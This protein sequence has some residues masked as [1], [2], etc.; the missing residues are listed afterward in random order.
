MEVDC[1]T[2]SCDGVGDAITYLLAYQQRERSYTIAIPIKP[3]LG[4]SWSNLDTN[5]GAAFQITE[6][7]LAAGY[8]VRVLAAGLTVVGSD[9]GFWQASLGLPRESYYRHENDF[10]V[11]VDQSE[12]ASV[13]LGR[14]AS[15]SAQ[16]PTPIDRVS[17]I[18]NA[19]PFG[20]WRI[21]FLKRPSGPSIADASDALLHLEISARAN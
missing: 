5:E 2:S 3:L 14:V 6:E 13:H 12:I 7:M 10:K 17:S 9:D 1:L 16:V 18:Y 15:Q 11:T 19:S 8:A 20:E 4:D 21:R